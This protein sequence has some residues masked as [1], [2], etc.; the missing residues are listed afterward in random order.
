MTSAGPA[1]RDEPSA[2][3]AAA[4]PTT[5]KIPEPMIAPTPRIIKSQTPSVFSKPPELAS[6]SISSGFL[7]L[8]IVFKKLRVNVA[9]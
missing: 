3:P 4:I 1:P 7:I 2:F 5:A 6:A 9:R 8:V